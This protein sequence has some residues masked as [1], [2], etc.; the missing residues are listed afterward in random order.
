MKKKPKDKMATIALDLEI[1]YQFD[2]RRVAILEKIYLNK[3]MGVTSSYFWNVLS[4]ILTPEYIKRHPEKPWGHTCKC[5]VCDDNITYDT[6]ETL[7]EME[8]QIKQIKQYVKPIFCPCDECNKLT[9]KISNLHRNQWTKFSANPNLTLEL[10]EKYWDSD[11]HVYSLA[12]NP[13]TAAKARFKKEYLAALKIQEMFLQAKFNPEYAY[14]RR[15]HSEF[16]QSL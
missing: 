11:W 15:L 16:Y 14:C 4:Q 1:D 7:A 3:N 8:E 9:Y 2:S 10:I 13:M 12:K 5:L 6:L